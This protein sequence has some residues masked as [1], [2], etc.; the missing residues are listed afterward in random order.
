[1]YV[2]NALSGV[3]EIIAAPCTVLVLKKLGR[4]ISVSAAFLCA[5][6]MCITAS[7]INYCFPGKIW[8]LPIRMYKRYWHQQTTCVLRSIYHDSNVDNQM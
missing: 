6:F 3:A 4:R 8:I 2:N 1:M 7:I 5:G